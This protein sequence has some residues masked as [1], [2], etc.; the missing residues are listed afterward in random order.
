MEKNLKNMRKQLKDT[1]TFYTPIKLANKMKSYIDFKPKMVYD[2]TAGQGNLLSVFDDD[3]EKY[4]QEID[5]DELEKA[6]ANLVN[7]YGYAGDTLKDDYFK[8]MKF[9][10]IFSNPPYSIKWE[11]ND[12]DERFKQ[13]GTIPPAGKADFAFLLHIIHHLS[14]DGVAV[15]L[16][17]PGV[18]YRGQRE[19]K[20]RQ[21][22][23]EQNYIER[24]VHVPENSG[25]SDTKIATCIWILRKNKTTTD[26]VFEDMEKKKEKIVSFDEVKSQNFNLSVS[27]YIEDDTPKKIADPIDLRKKARQQ[28][29]QNLM[30]GLKVDAICCELDGNM[31]DHLQLINEVKKALLEYEM[32][33]LGTK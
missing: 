24:I 21:W 17:S 26:I 22:F 15:V 18:C 20:I 8:D 5:A 10:C 19:G 11:Q 6:K 16:N 1:G 23:V 4:G 30:Y 32:E 2:P 33:F 27:T 7:F 13:A 28:S 25:F 9:D 14:E 12:K 3:V 29:I 31:M